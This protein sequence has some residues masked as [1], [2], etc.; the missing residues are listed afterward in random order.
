MNTLPAEIILRVFGEAGLNGACSARYIYI[1]ISYS[2]SI[3]LSNSLKTPTNFT[4][5]DLNIR[6]SHVA[7]GTSSCG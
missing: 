6:V 5:S 7:A 3:E 1:E 2:L 4:R